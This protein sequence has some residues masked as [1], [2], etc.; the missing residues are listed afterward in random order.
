MMWREPFTSISNSNSNSDIDVNE[1]VYDT[2]TSCTRSSRK[3]QHIF[4][5]PYSYIMENSIIPI[6]NNFN[7][8]L[9]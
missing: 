4:I 9:I 8:K 7:H 2:L 6:A 5:F 1:N 3:S